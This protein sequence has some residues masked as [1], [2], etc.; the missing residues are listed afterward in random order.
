MIH[1]YKEDAPSYFMIKFWF[2]QFKKVEVLVLADRRIRVL[3]IADEVGISEATV[4]KILHES[5]GINKLLM[6][7]KN[8]VG[9]T[10]SKKTW[11]LWLTTKSFFRKTGSETWMYHWDPPTK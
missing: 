11:G 1:L 7:N 3:M 10:F 4:L 6:P 9:N 2:N 5:L 8:C